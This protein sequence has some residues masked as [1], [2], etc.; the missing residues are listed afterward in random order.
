[1]SVTANDLAKQANT[2]GKIMR[3][4]L[5]KEWRAGR[6]SHRLYDRWVFTESEAETLLTIFSLNRS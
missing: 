4:F 1:M 5:R 6:I 2:T 3:N